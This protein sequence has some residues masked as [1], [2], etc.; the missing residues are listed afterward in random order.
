MRKQCLRLRY[1]S[2]AWHPQQSPG[3]PCKC[4]LT[5]ANPPHLTHAD[6]SLDADSPSEDWFTR[7]PKA[8]R[9][10]ASP[11]AAHGNAGADA[12]GDQDEHAGGSEKDE[13]GHADGAS[14]SLLASLEHLAEAT[15]ALL[16]RCEDRVQSLMAAWDQAEREREEEGMARMMEREEWCQQ[17]EAYVR[18][19]AEMEREG[20][21]C[22]GHL[23][24]EIDRLLSK[25]RNSVCVCVCASVYVCA[26]REVD[27]TAD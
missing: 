5:S 23:E 26:K 21:D 11:G 22:V 15:E 13:A 16:R 1:T 17:S 25:V 8:L 12:A 19:I 4:N 3:P 20:E 2:Q 9:F 24:G 18:R 6:P 10:P 7:T 27:L 14:V